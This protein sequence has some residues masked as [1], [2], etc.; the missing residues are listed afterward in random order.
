M[1]E[2]QCTEQAYALLCDGGSDLGAQNNFA[3]LVRV[4]D[5]GAQQR[6][7]RFLDMPACNN[8]TGGD[9]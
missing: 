8:A 6:K 4:Y 3:L 9:V 2:K 1:V 5:E 7:T